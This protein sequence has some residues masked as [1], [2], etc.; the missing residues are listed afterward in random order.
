MCQLCDAGGGD[1]GSQCNG[2]QV[3]FFAAVMLKYEEF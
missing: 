1:T 3:F 2:L